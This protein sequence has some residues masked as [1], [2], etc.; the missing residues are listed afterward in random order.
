MHDHRLK[1]TPTDRR[2]SRRS[3]VLQAGLVA[4]GSALGSPLLGCAESQTQIPCL[5]PAA[6]P[7]PI[8]GMT[9]I[10]ASEIGCAL[11]CDLVTGRNKYHDGPPTDDGPRINAA[12]AGASASNPITLIIDGSALISGL[13]LPAGGYWGIAGLGCGTGFLTKAGI[14]NDA[15]H[16]G[17]PDAASITDP[18]PPAP[19]RGRNVF[20][21]NFTLNGNRGNGHTGVSTTGEPQGN[22]K[23]WYFG[24]NLMSLDDIT[25]ENLVI[26]NTPAYNIR[27][28][29]VGNVSVS[30]CVIQGQGANT[31]GLHFDGPSNDITIA[32]CSFATGDDSIALNCPEG[33]TGN[34]SRVTVTGCT[35]NS[36]SLMRLYTAG[37]LGHFEID[38]VTVS[39]CSGTMA[40]AAFPIGFIANGNPNAV[41]SLSVSDCT[42]T[43]PVVFGVAEN[44]GILRARNITFFPMSLDWKKQSD[45]SAG[46]LRPSPWPNGLNSWTG[47]NVILEN[48]KVIRRDSTGFAAIVMEKQ[49]TIASVEFD[50][51]TVQQ[52]G[53]T[54]LAPAL[55]H[56]GP[57]SVQQLILNSVDSSH[58]RAPVDASGFTGIGTVSGTGVLA[59][60]WKFPDAVMANGVPYISATTGEPS[61][62]VN[63]VV[64]AY[65]P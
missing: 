59:T 24:I 17:P 10:R 37:P 29:N 33:Y 6:A 12:M 65:S 56:L 62:K 52:A 7:V 20:L 21:S 47:S 34:I 4:A 1:T 25:I 13:F 8:P 64:E 51:F 43:A 5:G 49:S 35:F 45:Q 41:T 18:G 55:L 63:G 31:D 36:L 46:F 3:F 30:G 61:I 23:V 50:G 40:E 2:I 15:I 14:N 16:N 54:D 60:G 22:D 11:D 44:F 19:P 9:Y 28:S 38:N 57:G 39:D 26:V 48:C 53:F 32:N 58:I 42:L 27:L